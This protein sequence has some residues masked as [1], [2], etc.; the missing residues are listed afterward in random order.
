MKFTKDV[1]LPDSSFP[2]LNVEIKINTNTFNSWIYRKPTHTN[3]FLNY[4]AIAPDSFKRGLI[5]GL[6]TRAKRL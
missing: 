2:F 3:V 1:A 4:K 5:L 6:L